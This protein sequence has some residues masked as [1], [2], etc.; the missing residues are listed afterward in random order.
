MV[1]FKE[2]FEMNVKGIQTKYQYK[3]N[4]LRDKKQNSF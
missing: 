3:R 4:I 2:G 1:I